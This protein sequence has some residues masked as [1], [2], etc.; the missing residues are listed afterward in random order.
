MLHGPRN[1][2]ESHPI[3]GSWLNQIFHGSL[4]KE[5]DQ[6]LRIGNPKNSSCLDIQFTRMHLLFWI[7][8]T[9]FIEAMVCSLWLFNDIYLKISSQAFF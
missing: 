2:E 3:S 8:F 6:G 4:V 7:R 1:L 9:V 5:F